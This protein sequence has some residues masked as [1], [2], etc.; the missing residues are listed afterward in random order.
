MFVFLAFVSTASADLGVRMVDY[1]PDPVEPGEKFIVN[2]EIDNL[3][4]TSEVYEVKLFVHD[5]FYLQHSTHTLVE[6]NGYS[7]EEVSFRV[8]VDDDA[9]ELSSEISFA[10][11]LEGED[12]WITKDFEIDI[13]NE[14]SLQ[15]VSVS[16]DP[17]V[18]KKGEK[19][20]LRVILENDGDVNLENIK[21]ELDL[22]MLPLA[23][24]GSVSFVELGSL[25]IRETDVAILNIVAL[26][27]AASGFYKIPVIIEYEDEHGKDYDSLSY[28]SVRVGAESNID[29]IPETS[30]LICNSKNTVDLKLVNKGDGDAEFLEAE[31]LN[32]NGYSILGVNKLYIGQIDSDD[33]EDLSYDIFI[34]NKDVELMLSLKYK[35][36]SGQEFNKLFKIPINCFTKSEAQTL[37]LIEK[38]N[39]L[40]FWI[41]GVVVVIGFFVIRRKR[42]KF[43]E[44]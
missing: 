39:N 13:D 7:E 29:V 12:D 22:S 8:E 18:I 26:D 42:K 5:P 15:V 1:N 16:S 28:I 41:I 43:E 6:I 27:E 34:T 30:Y 35:D 11:R 10:Y 14:V 17:S 9:D 21:V 23:P 32:S 36:D 3:E 37:G 38:N 24:Y 19:A 31:L 44:E 4:D 25:D 2:F 20:E 33:Y 40:V